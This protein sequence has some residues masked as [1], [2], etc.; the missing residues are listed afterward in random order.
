MISFE[1]CEIVIVIVAFAGGLWH[2]YRLG[3]KAGYMQAVEDVALE[4]IEVKVYESDD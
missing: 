3:T 1:L 4:R 2:L